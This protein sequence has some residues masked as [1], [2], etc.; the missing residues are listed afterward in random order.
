M[1]IKVS[2][3]NLIYSSH[4]AHTQ[5]FLG[6]AGCAPLGPTGV[7]STTRKCGISSGWVANQR[8]PQNSSPTRQEQPWWCLLWQ[9]LTG[10]SQG[11]WIMVWGKCQHSEW[12][13]HVPASPWESCLGQRKDIQNRRGKYGPCYAS[14]PK[15]SRLTHV[16][17]G[18]SLWSP[19]GNSSLSLI[20]LTDLIKFWGVFLA[21]PMDFDDCRT[22]Q[23]LITYISLVEKK[24]LFSYNW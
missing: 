8:S 11:F 19:L 21:A 6:S 15:L 2:A 13:P 17:P 22:A 7:S 3:Q 23:I 9:S 10:G 16:K 4:T 5:S 1:G 14:A 12:G 18:A 24:F 20:S